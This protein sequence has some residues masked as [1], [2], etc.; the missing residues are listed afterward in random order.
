MPEQI[1]LSAQMSAC[2]ELC[3][4]CQLVCL[5]IATGH[6]PGKGGPHVAAEPLRALLA[7]AAVCDAAAT[8]MT[9]GA[10]LHRKLC[11]VCAEACDACI[12]SCRGLD[13]M[14]ECIF[15]C[16]RCKLSCEAMTAA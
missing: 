10:P 1:A 7:C 13:E 9:I 11:A 16:E 15:A 5:N 12:S 3:R 8:L 2:I 14:E 6:C 4:R